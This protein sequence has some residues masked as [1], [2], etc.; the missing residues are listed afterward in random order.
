MADTG[1]CHLSTAFTLLLLLLS[2]HRH[3]A[4]FQLSTSCRHR[5]V[6]VIPSWFFLCYFVG[7]TALSSTHCCHAIA[8]ISPSAC[9]CCHAI[10]IMPSSLYHCN[11]FS[12]VTSLSP[13]RCRYTFSDHHTI[14]HRH[15]SSINVTLSSHHPYTIVVTSALSIPWSSCSHRH[16]I[17]ATPTSIIPWLSHF[18]VM[19]RLRRPWAFYAAKHDGIALAR[20]PSNEAARDQTWPNSGFPITRR[21]CLSSP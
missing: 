18:F 11:H 7:A 16:T 2:H 14:Y 19:R 4:V 10:V 1:H 17:V 9:L 20:A 13:C 12:I 8:L 5:K 21:K 15:Q 6:A 3:H